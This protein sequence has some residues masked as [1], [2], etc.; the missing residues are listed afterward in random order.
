M[1]EL[2]DGD[3][4]L[5]VDQAEDDIGQELSARYIDQLARQGK[6]RAQRLPKKASIL[7]Y[8]SSLRE[9]LASKRKPGPKR[10]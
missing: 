3:A 1:I 6:I 10:K 2:H 8:R 7:V 9:Y 4:L 5:T